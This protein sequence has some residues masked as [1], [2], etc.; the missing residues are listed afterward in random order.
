MPVGQEFAGI[1]RK[2][3]LTGGA[4][5]PISFGNDPYVDTHC[6]LDDRERPIKM[7]HKNFTN[8]LV[9]R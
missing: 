7:Q 4:I 1:T 5:P 2:L 9:V 3:E 6:R 8:M